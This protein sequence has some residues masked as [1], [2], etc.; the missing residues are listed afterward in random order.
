MTTDTIAEKIVEASNL[1]RIA[2]DSSRDAIQRQ[3]A[4]NALDGLKYELAKEMP[5]QL[6]VQ[7]GAT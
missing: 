4:F 2:F 1:E 3:I 7:L 5:I 6:I